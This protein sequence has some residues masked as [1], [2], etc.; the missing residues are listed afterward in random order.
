MMMTD[1]VTL[2]A[3]EPYQI[4]DS[5]APAGHGELITPSDADNNFFRSLYVGTAG[6]LSVEMASGSTV[7]FDN[8]SGF[9]PIRVNKVLAT[10]TTAAKIIGLS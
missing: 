2:Q 6:S 3:G 9:M 8:A 5:Q 7:T 1:I 10:G 4:G